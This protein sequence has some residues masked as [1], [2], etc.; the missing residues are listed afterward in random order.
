[1]KNIKNQKGAISLFVILAMLFF[2]AFM[3][4]VFSI[5]TRRNAAQ[6]EA[7][8]RTASNCAAFLLVVIENTPSINAKKKSIAN[9]TN[10]DIA[11]F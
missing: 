6:L 11:P 4:G 3:L 1:M 9:I 10:N 7:V 2:L 8:S 5:T